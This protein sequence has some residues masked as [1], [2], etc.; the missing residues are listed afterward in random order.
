M[1]T[2]WGFCLLLCWMLT[3]CHPKPQAHEVIGRTA[4]D[5]LTEMKNDSA[6]N[7]PEIGG[8]ETMIGPVTVRGILQHTKGKMGSLNG[9]ILPGNYLTPEGHGYNWKPEFEAMVGKQVEIKGVHYRYRCGPMEQCLDS[10]VIN[11][12]REIEYLKLVD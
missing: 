4:N 9:F 6:Y 11:Y 7:S 5:S 8:K 10:G 3:A 12:L 1:K 2:A